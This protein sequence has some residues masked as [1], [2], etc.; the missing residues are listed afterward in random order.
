MKIIKSIL[1][2]VTMLLFGA[3]FGFFGANYLIDSDLTWF[4]FGLVIVA[5][6]VSFLLHLTIHEFGHLVFGK[7]SGYKML[8]FRIFSHMWVKNNGKLEYKRLSI[9]G[10]LG[11]CLMI[12]PKKVNGH[13]PFKLYLLGG[14]FMNIIIAFI[15]LIISLILDMTSIYVMAFV[16]AGLLTAMVNLIPYSFNDGSTLSKA[17]K[18]PEIRNILYNQ[19][20][21]NAETSVGT[22]F[23]ELPEEWIQ[24]PAS[25]DY[26]NIFHIWTLLVPYQCALEEKNYQTAQE[27]IDDIWDK[28]DAKN[29]YRME[30]AKEW[31]FIHLFLDQERDKVIALYNQKDVKANLKIKMVSH[32]R[33][34]AM[35]A[36]K[37]DQDYDKAMTLFN[38]A[39]ELLAQHP[40][41]ADSLLE[42]EIIDIC[43]KRLK[44]DR[45][46]TVKEA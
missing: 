21:V 29:F 43:K 44:E 40:N 30:V 25:V 11:Q 1:F 5:F 22:K 15:V 17:K 23:I 31:L 24:K 19:L 4:D 38:E 39:L 42:E 8:S 12:P 14:G 34:K 37:I 28:I 27:I 10:T 46:S 7:L 3:A 9:P 6:F 2:T 20:M 45:Q 41:K 13:F 35:Y 16:L 33:I 32:A 36:W 18:D 26:S